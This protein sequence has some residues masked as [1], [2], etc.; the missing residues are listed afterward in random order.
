M[1]KLLFD[2]SNHQNLNQNANNS[3][4]SDEEF[5]KY[6]L[7]VDNPIIKRLATVAEHLMETAEA[8]RLALQEV[9]DFLESVSVTSSEDGSQPEDLEEADI[10]IDDLAHKVITLETENCRLQNK[11]LE[12]DP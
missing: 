3:L 8:D 4:Y 7:Q 2:R 1:N 11:I 12:L 9:V 10:W 5:V 6:A